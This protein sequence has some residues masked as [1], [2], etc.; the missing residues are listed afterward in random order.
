[1][2]DTQSTGTPATGVRANAKNVSLR[3]ANTRSMG[4]RNA[5]MPISTERPNMGTVSNNTLMTKNVL[6]AL[7][8]RMSDQFESINHE[9]RAMRIL[10]MGV[11]EHVI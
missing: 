7:V 8:T 3:I 11:P 1:M 9:A 10:A 4:H 6:G 5:C 2:S